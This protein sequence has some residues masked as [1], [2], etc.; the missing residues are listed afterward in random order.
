[1]HKLLAILDTKTESNIFRE[2]QLSAFSRAQIM[3]VTKSTNVYNAN[4]R[5]L[6]IACI[7]KLYVHIGS[8]INLVNFLLFGRLGVPAVLGCEFGEH[9][10]ECNNPKAR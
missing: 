6:R 3:R 7:V 1:M 8:K 2:E 9:L 4:N 5:S 10:V